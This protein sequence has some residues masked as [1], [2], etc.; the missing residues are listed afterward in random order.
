MIELGQLEAEHE[1]FD[2]RQARV[3]V[4]SIEDQETARQTQASF[5]HL[6]VVADADRQLSKAI[7]V[8]HRKSAIDGGDT[9]APTTL[10]IDDQ[11]MVRW[12]FRP[13]RFLK[14]LS[15]AEL[16]AALDEWIPSGT[17]H[18]QR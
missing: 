5:P 15:P 16:M 17:Q 9:S 7:D 1:M 3:I 4:V 6:V 18:S 8:I 10:L 11:G 12:L 2:K 13:D 14:R